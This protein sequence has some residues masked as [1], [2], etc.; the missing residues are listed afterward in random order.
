MGYHKE[1]EKMTKE[2]VLKAE[3]ENEILV[4]DSDTKL[5]II[6]NYK[7]YSCPK[8]GKWMEASEY[9]Y[10]SSK[11]DFRTLRHELQKAVE[12]SAKLYQCPKCKFVVFLE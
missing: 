8:C 10:N 6:K 5:R 3:R 11:I 12:M 7:K 2:E 1:L 9:E 4:H